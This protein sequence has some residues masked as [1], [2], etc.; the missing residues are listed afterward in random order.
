MIA[1]GVITLVLATSTAVGA[2]ILAVLTLWFLDPL[3][4]AFHKGD[5]NDL[6]MW[7]LGSAVFVVVLSV[8][9]DCF[10]VGL[11]NGRSWARR[12][13]LVLC[14][15]TALLGIAGAYY[16]VPLIVTLAAVMVA[17]LLLVPAARAW[18]RQ[19]SGVKSEAQP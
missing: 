9:A 16:V 10:A 2:I 12:A 11:L 6:R 5:A 15:P 4:D 19:G 7:V 1:A 3:F 13:L 14:L 18:F 8:L 17:V